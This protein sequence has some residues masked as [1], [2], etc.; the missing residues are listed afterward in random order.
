MKSKRSSHHRRVLT[1]YSSEDREQLIQQYLSSGQGKAAFCRERQINLGTFCGWLK[2]LS[3]TR[4]EFAE[5]TLAG[6]GAERPSDFVRERIEV[7]FPS[8]VRVF[9]PERRSP[10]ETG[11]LIR[12]VIG[13]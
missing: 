13:C 3:A 11:C 1:R 5:V 2:R 8:G 12:E 4:S 6:N 10:T 7:H 9:F